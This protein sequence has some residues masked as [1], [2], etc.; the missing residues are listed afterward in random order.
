MPVKAVVISI[1]KHMNLK[2]LPTK[3]SPINEAKLLWYHFLFIVKCMPEVVIDSSISSTILNW[4]LQTHQHT[5]TH[6]M[7]HFSIGGCLTTI[8]TPVPHNSVHCLVLWSATETVVLRSQV[9][10]LNGDTYYWWAQ[11]SFC[12]LADKMIKLYKIRDLLNEETISWARVIELVYEFDEKSPVKCFRKY[13]LNYFWV[14][15]IHSKNINI[16]Y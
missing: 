7:N 14:T 1:V 2:V 9:H 11:S 15:Y 4:S 16:S 3:N 12:Q 10:L 13:H 8:T 5:H 6:M